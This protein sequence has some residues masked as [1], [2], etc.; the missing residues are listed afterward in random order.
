QLDL[1]VGEDLL[2]AR[3]RPLEA[4]LL[5]GGPLVLLE[6][7]GR[8]HQTGPDPELRETGGDALVGR[9][10]QTPHPAQAHH[11]DADVAHGCSFA[12]VRGQ[13]RRPTGR[14]ADGSM[15]ADAPAERDQSPPSSLRIRS[16]IRM[17]IASAS[18]S[19][20]N[21]HTETG[22]SYSRSRRQAK[23]TSQ[24]ISPLPISLCWWM[25]ASTPGGFMMY[26]LPTLAV[27]SKTSAMCR[28]FSRS[29]A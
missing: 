14:S 7:I 25:R 22:P 1:R 28:C 15:R 26:R 23:A 8:H 21:T 17:L 11:A 19:Q 18:S 27:W 29:P 5:D 4:E 3:H 6:R 10:V 9:G 24:S 13:G 12:A 20:P 16:R 2:D